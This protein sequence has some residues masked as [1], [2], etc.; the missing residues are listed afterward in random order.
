MLSTLRAKIAVAVTLAVTLFLAALPV[1]TVFAACSATV[2]NTANDFSAGSLKSAISSAGSGGTVCFNIPGAGV[3]TINLTSTLSISQ[4]VIIDGT[5]QPG[6]TGAPLIEISGANAGNVNGILISGGN[7]TILG[8][9]VNRFQGDGILIQTNG[10]NTIAGSYIGTDATGTTDLG[11]G[12]SGIGILSNNNTIGGSSAGAR[13][14]VSGNN[15]N[16]IVVGGGATGNTIKG[17]YIGTNAAG[18]SSVANTADGILIVQAPNNTIGGTNSVTPGGAC[19][20]DCNLISGNG[21]NGVGIWQSGA[22]GNSVKGNFIGVNP[23]GTGAVANG[24]IGLEIQDAANNTVGGTTA[25]DRNVISG[26]I[27]AGVS[28]TSTG[29]TGNKIEGNYIGVNTTGNAAIKNHKMGVNIGST[30]GGSSNASGN[31]IGGTTGT[32]PGGSCTGACN[33]IA[34]NNWSGVYISGSTGGNNEIVGNF[35]GAGA[36]GGWTIPNAQDGIGIVDSPNNR[37]GG[38]ASSAR[39]I[40]SGNGTNGIAIVGGNANGT[41]IEGNYI[42]IATDQNVMPNQT[43]GVAVGAG[44]DTAI[45]ANSI[46]GNGFMGIDVSLGG[47]TPNDGGDPDNGPNRLQNFPQLAYA[48][49]YGSGTNFAGSLNSNASTSYRLEFFS[50]LACSAQGYGQ[51]RYYIGGTTVVTDASGNTNFNFVLPGNITGGSAVTATA[52]KLGGA[53]PF[54]TSEF[55]RCIYVPRQHPDGTLITPVGSPNIFLIEGNLVRPI[56]SSEV[57]ASYNITSAEFKTATNGDTNLSGGANLYFKEG[58]LIK[59][60][61]PDVFVI[62]QTG[63]GAYVKRKITS[64]QFFTGLGYTESDI[65]RVPDSALGATNGSDIS[66]NSRHP[67]GTLVKQL[68]G[69]S[70]YLVED[71]KIRLIG[72]PGVL[73]SNRFRTDRVKTATVTDLS[74]GVGPNV[75]FREGAVLKGSGANV[76]VVD[77][78]DSGIKKRRIASSSAMIELGYKNSDIITVPDNELPVADGPGI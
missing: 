58:T 20:G 41:R 65:I 22:T 25:A 51:G 49:P 61:G 36:S 62:D 47:V 72:S 6:Y 19:T 24:D 29:A 8:L 54:E 32:T 40:I 52:T 53:T 17:N 13:N 5:T 70:I 74:S 77:S 3:H 39:N 69:N 73:I 4:P 33:V 45:L 1:S 64:I 66:D 35:I 44:V 75:D 76:Y 18:T 2:T 27:G 59:G 60:S 42:G 12:S 57:L 34:G 78:T 46:D 11:N 37:I 67:D 26:N 48:L 9:V 16:G 21:A 63:P 55:S 38:P 50:S 10:G 56:G 14:I 31:I 30:D 68:E 15:G 28:I 43:T 23:A 71:G 7:T